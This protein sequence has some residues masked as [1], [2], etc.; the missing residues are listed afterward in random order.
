MFFSQHQAVELF[1]YGF[2]LLVKSFWNLQV[3]SSRTI[4]CVVIYDICALVEPC[5]LK[6]MLLSTHATC[7]LCDLG[8]MSA[9]INATYSLCYIEA[10]SH[11]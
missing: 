7:H 3:F 4:T 2:A 11:L 8:L 6:R 10:K 1:L 9:G 5:Y